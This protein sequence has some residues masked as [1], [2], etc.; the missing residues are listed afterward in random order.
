MQIHLSVLI[1]FVARFRDT[2]NTKRG[3]VHFV[4]G[5]VCVVFLPKKNCF[6]TAFKAKKVINKWNNEFL[7]LPGDFLVEKVKGSVEFS[8]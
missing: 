2:P 7:C 5:H 6:T 1:M 3:L 8:F 4:E